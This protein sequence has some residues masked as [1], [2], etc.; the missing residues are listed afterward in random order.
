M[1]L[2]A[3]AAYDPRENAPAEVLEKLRGQGKLF[4]MTYPK[5][6]IFFEA[7]GANGLIAEIAGYCNKGS[8]IIVIAM[9]RHP[10]T[11]DGSRIMSKEVSIIGAS[12]YPSEFPEV[13]QKIA[14]GA[15]EPEK[16]ITH[17]F[18]FSEFLAAFDTATNPS[19]AAKVLLQFD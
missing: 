17:R 14:A 18:P 7:S 19:S 6:D 1:T 3:R 5:T 16:M 12:G 4:G 10:V 9:Q 8:R 15:I 2:G 11:L 13:M